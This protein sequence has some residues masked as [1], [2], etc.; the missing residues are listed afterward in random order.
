[1]KKSKHCMLAAC[2][3]VFSFAS[4]YLLFEWLQNE[5]TTQNHF[6]DDDD[7]CTDDDASS[8]QTVIYCVDVTMCRSN[9]NRKSS[10]NKTANIRHKHAQCTHT[11][12]HI[13]IW[14]CRKWTEAAKRIKDETKEKRTDR[15]RERK[16]DR[17]MRAKTL[18]APFLYVYVLHKAIFYK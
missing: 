2:M 5:H 18:W 1:M 14:I 17:K 11:P 10:N 3:R 13:Y 7:D 9:A 12:A 4:G 8:I 6:E 16:E 15:E